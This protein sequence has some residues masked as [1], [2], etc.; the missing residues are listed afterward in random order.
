MK[1]K[2][3]NELWLQQPKCVNFV[4]SEHSIQKSNFIITE[5]NVND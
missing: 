3:V 5:R 4:I 2:I 1:P